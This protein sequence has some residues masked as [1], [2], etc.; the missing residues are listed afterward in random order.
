MIRAYSIRSWPLFS[1][2][3][4][5]CV[6]RLEEENIALT[7]DDGPHPVWTPWVLDQLAKENLKATF[8]L[9]GNNVK[10]HPEIVRDLRS[11]G[12]SIG[13]HSTQHLDAWKTKHQEYVDDVVRTQ[14]LLQTKM[15]RPPY[16]HLTRKASR[17]LLA[18]DAVDD[19]MMWSMITGDFDTTVEPERCK[20]RVLKKVKERDIVVM[21]DSEKASPRLTATLPALIQLIKE[22]NWTTQTL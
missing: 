12:H 4:P 1:I 6:W 5:D 21:H 22:N 11:A 3:Y 20:E 10:K 9:I 7:F 13:G 2:Y 16:G 18:T 15:F 14:D 19:I 17:A 8:F